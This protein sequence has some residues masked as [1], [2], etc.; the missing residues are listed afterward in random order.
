M[1]ERR[2]NINCPSKVKKTDE[3]ITVLEEN[4]ILVVPLQD[5]KPANYNIIINQKGRESASSINLQ[6]GCR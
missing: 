1:G 4:P 2:V 5:P 6:Q 3:D